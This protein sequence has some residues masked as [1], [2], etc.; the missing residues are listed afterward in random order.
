MDN[1]IGNGLVV[2]TVA[3]AVWYLYRRYKR[4]MNS[5]NPG[6]SG[7]EGC[8]GSSG[9]HPFNDPLATPPE[10]TPKDPSLKNSQTGNAR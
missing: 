6:C 1:I 4:T 9:G 3:G 2:I 5:D 8:C 10:D 7:C